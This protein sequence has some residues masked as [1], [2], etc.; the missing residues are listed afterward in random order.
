MALDFSGTEAVV[1]GGSVQIVVPD[2]HPLIFLA[3][4]LNWQTLIEIVSADL[5]RSTAKGNWQVGRKL[6][7]RIHLAVY[8]L[9]VL[10][11]LTDRKAEYG[12]KDNVTFQLFCGLKIVA[13]W[14]TPDHTK[15]EKFRNRLRPATQNALAN[16]LAKF[17]V[18]QGLADASEADFDSTVQEANIAYPADANLMT[19]L[20]GL[21]KKIIGY[22]GEK[23]RGIL[24]KGL[25]VDM[26][27]IK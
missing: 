23:M 13:N 19:K 3:N 10:Y 25:G 20:A 7:V 5:M 12:V 26:K 4:A 2:S 16:E 9:Q 21:G 24:P 18:A 6:Q 17:A 8:L 11:N 27:K 1:A 15:I 14:H 22:F